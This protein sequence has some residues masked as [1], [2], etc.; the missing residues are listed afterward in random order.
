MDL[1]RFFRSATVAMLKD[2]VKRRA[3]EDL[4]LE[5][6]VVNDPDLNHSDDKRNLAQA[7]SGFSNSSISSIPTFVPNSRGMFVVKNAPLDDMSRVTTP[8]SPPDM[9]SWL[10]A[11]DCSD[12]G[13]RRANLSSFLL[14]SMLP[15]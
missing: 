15:R 1:E 14:S 7:L 4:F 8:N 2:L 5:F 11:M 3:Q 9:P 6:K 10:R 13:R 12:P